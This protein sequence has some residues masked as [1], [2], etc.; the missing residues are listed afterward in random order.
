VQAQ[1]GERVLA[2]FVTGL[3]DDEGLDCFALDRIG[4]ADDGCLGDGWMRD[5]RR[6][7]LR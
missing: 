3:E 1:V 4:L 5:E 7:D 6:L 2:A